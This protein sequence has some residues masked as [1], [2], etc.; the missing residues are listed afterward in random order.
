MSSA[1][2]RRCLPHAT[3]A[4]R[5]SEVVASGE[6]SGLTDSA[7]RTALTSAAGSVL[8][9]SFPLV[10]ARRFRA[11]AP[12]SSRRMN[13]PDPASSFAAS[14]HPPPHVR[15]PKLIAWV[16]DI[17]ARSRPERHRLVRRLAAGIRPAVRGD[18]RDAGTLRRLN[19][20]KRPEQL[21]RLVRSVGRRA[22]RGPH[23]HLQR[24][25][26]GRRPD[27]QLGGA[28]RDAPQDRR[29]CSKAACAGAR[30]T[31]CRFR[32]ARSAARSRTSASSSPTVP[33]VVGQHAHHDAHG[34]ARRSTC[35]AP[36]AS[37]CRACIRS[38]RRWRRARRTCRGRAIPSTS[39]SSIFPRR[40][41]SGATA[42][43][44]AA[45][46]CSARSALRCASL[47]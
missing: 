27:E 32:W 5:R 45:T 30:C 35:S 11:C 46:R 43:A 4:R 12:Y 29:A 40:A 16:R 41:R 47:R 13:A 21:P 24:A 42:R 44:T 22:R 2:G 37:S 23:V 14:L 9:L 17:A 6:P 38:A 19:P 33:Y 8:E 10:L 1:R 20:A 26:G 34:H 28:G 39:T 36:T 31:S 18:G 15:H 3:A 25:R 7:A